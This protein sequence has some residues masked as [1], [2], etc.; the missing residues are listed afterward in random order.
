MKAGASDPKS[1]Q[2]AKS[3]EDENKQPEWKCRSVTLYERV[4]LV[5]RGTFG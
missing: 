2:P 1:P 4:T 3:K 5:G